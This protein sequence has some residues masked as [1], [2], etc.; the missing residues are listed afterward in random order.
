MLNVETIKVTR[1]RQL[2]QQRLQRALRAAVSMA[3]LCAVAV[4]ALPERATLPA[5]FVGAAAALVL[6]GVAACYRP[7]WRAHRS[8]P[9]SGTTEEDIASTYR[10]CV[11]REVRL[12]TIAA[13]LLGAGAV[14]TTIVRYGINE[15]LVLVAVGACA[16]TF[17][18][19]AGVRRHSRR[20][21]KITS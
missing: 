11:A 21:L 10:R 18:A 17:L 9:E 5:L 16:A 6:A 2:C 19:L 20:T 12:A 3:A 13:P 14:V 1:I 4:L 15:T 7:V 8:A